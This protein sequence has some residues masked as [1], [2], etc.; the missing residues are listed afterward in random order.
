MF[1]DPI[2]EVNGFPIRFAKT[3][4][5]QKEVF[6]AMVIFFTMALI[7]AFVIVLTDW[8][9]RDSIFKSRINQLIVIFIGF[10]LLIPLVLFLKEMIEKSGYIVPSSWEIYLGFFIGLLVFF[11]ATRLRFGNLI[12]KP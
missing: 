1:N 12:E 7:V 10:V 3:L 9:V 5:Q 8:R 4:I 11:V 6:I 2:T